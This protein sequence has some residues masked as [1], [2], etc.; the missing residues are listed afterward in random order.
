MLGRRSIGRRLN[1]TWPMP[2]RP[3]SLVALALFVSVEASAQATR[4][5]RL[6]ELRRAGQL[7][8]GGETAPAR[9]LV[10]SL[11]A[12]VALGGHEIP[13]LL[14]ARASL[15]LRWADADADYRRIVAE[16]PASP[17]REESLLRLGQQALMDDD[18]QTA[19]RDLQQLSAEYRSDSSQARVNYWFARVL[20]ENHDLRS[21]CTASDRAVAHLASADPSTR[22]RI[23]ALASSNCARI[24]DTAVTVAPRPTD[25][26]PRVSAPANP[27]AATVRRSYAV[28]VAAFATRLG[29]DQLAARLRNTGLPARVDGTKQPFRVRIGSYATYAEAVAA[30]RDLRRRKLTGFVTEVRP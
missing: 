16:F 6:L 25:N 2:F 11:I 8:S 27:S 4:D 3:I 13:D 24:V 29:A 28:Q 26:E 21:A 20:I 30:Q 7:A 17:R 15:A 12:T 9:Q 14:F 10:D 23:E 18:R 22:A 19:L 1:K 5:V